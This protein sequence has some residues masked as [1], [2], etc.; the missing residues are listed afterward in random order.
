MIDITSD[1][2]VLN[3]SY[4]KINVIRQGE[5]SDTFLITTSKKKLIAKKFKNQNFINLLF[6]V[7]YISKS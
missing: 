3:I 6:S 7:L 2:K 1:L 4:D 5:N